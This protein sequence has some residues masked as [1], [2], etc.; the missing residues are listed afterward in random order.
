MP[1]ILVVPFN[2]QEIGQGYN[3]ETRESIGTALSISQVSEDAAADGQEVT[4]TFESVTS[5][6]NLMESLGISA[7]AD[8][9]YGLFSGGAKFDFAQS[10]AVNSYSSFIAGRC[11]VHNAIR[12]GHDFR[13]TADAAALVTA[14][15]MDEF[16][17]AFGDMFV[18]SLKTGGEFDVVA[19]ITSVSEEHQSKMAASLHAAYN[20][21]AT[22]ADFQA[23]FNTAMQQTSNQTEVTVFMSQAGGIGEQASFTGPD[24]TKILDRLSH[25]PQSVHDHPVGYEAE[26]ASYNTIP[27]PVH[28]AE[29]REDRE[30]V[31]RD[32]L[33]QKMGFLKALADL[34]LLLDPEKASLFFDNLPPPEQLLNIQGQY[35]AALNNLMAHAIRVSTGKMDPPQMFVASPSP[36]PLNFKKKEFVFRTPNF[37]RLPIG[38]GIAIA[39]DLP[40][41]ADPEEYRE[42]ADIRA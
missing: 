36:T 8:V 38:A 41:S 21:L 20:G 39:Q 2:G 42:M 23:S 16:K 33:A 15:R 6:E 7:S 26:L 32:C 22:S 12:H 19:R 14:E 3:S 11:V 18:R 17:T 30:L 9:R 29:E 24:A 37:I 10:H 1:Q 31:L 28:T 13:L 40:N 5:Q 25:F 35:R 34:Q 27:I 4:T